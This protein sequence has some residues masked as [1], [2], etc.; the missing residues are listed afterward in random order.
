M[1]TGKK[2]LSIVLLVGIMILTLFGFA[3][4]EV[5]V[6]PA[7][8]IT[9]SATQ[10]GTVTAN[11]ERAAEGNEVTL[12]VTPNAKYVLSQLKANETELTLDEDGAARFTMPATEV[13]ITAEF[14]RE[15]FAVNLPTEVV[16]G[17][18][19][20]DAEK[21]IE[22]AT[23]TLTATPSFGYETKAVTV[24]GEAITAQDG[25]YS[26]VMPGK[27]VDV[28]V[29]YVI[30]KNA[31]TETAPEGVKLTAEAVAGKTATGIFT[32]EYAEEGVSMAAYVEDAMITQ[33]DCVSFYLGANAYANGGL[34]DS[35][36]SIIATVEGVKLYTVADGKYVESADA[37]N[38]QV[39]PWVVNGEVKGYAVKALA[40][41]EML[42]VEK[43]AAKGNVTVLFSL[44]NCDK[45]TLTKIVVYG[46]G[47]ADNADTFALLNEDGTLSE[48]YYKYGAGQLGQGDTAIKTGVH[49]NLSKDYGVNSENYADRKAVLSGHDGSDNNL[50]MFRATGQNLYA[51]AT[52]KLTGIANSSERYGKF[53]IMLF[54]ESAGS[55]FFFYVDA[56][57]G[58]D[59]EVKLDNVKGTE[60]GY[61]SAP[62]GW[63][64]WN[65]ISGTSGSFDLTTKTI[66]LGLTA[67]DG[68]IYMY[69]GDKL[70][71]ETTFDLGDGAVMGFKSFAFNMEVTDYYSTSDLDDPAFK[72]HRVEKTPVALEA[73]FLGDS[74]MDFWTWS[75]FS[76]HTAA[77]EGAKQDIG[78]GGTKISYWTNKIGYVKKMYSSVDKFIFHIGVNDIDDGNTTPEATFELLKEMIAVYQNAFPDAEIYWVS[79]VHN[80]MFANKCANYDKMNQYVYDYAKTIEKLHYIDV[81]SV[82]VD[83][84]GNTRTNMFY[85]GLHFN[86]EYG[87]PLWGK[88]IMEAIGYGDARAEGETLGDIE[89]KYAYNVW[90]F[91]EDGKV[92]KTTASGEQAIYFKDM[93]YATDFVASVDVYS[94]GLSGSDDW[95]KV[96]VILRNDNYSIFGYADTNIYGD[97]KDC[98]IVYRANANNDASV[99]TTANWGWG[100]QGSGGRANES[101]T[102]KY[103][104]ISVAKLGGTIYMLVNGNIVASHT[105]ISGI[106][107]QAFVAGVMGFNRIIEAKNA[108]VVTDKDAVMIALGLKAADAEL[109]GVADDDVWTDEVLS[110]TLTLGKRAEGSYFDV[111]AVKG[112]DGVYF[113]ATIYHKQALT[114]LAQGTDGNWWEWLNLEMRFGTDEGTQRVVYF[115]NGKVNSFGGVVVGDYVTEKSGD[116]NK[117]TVEFFANYM[118]F[119]GYTAENDEIA[120]KF[121]GWVAETGWLAIEATPTVS[122]H[123]LRYKHTATLTGADIEVP[124]V[125][126]KGDVITFKVPLEEGDIVGYV[127]VNGTEIQAKEDVYTIV[128]GDEDVK[129]EIS[130]LGRH[131]VT[132]DN[133][134]GKVAVS[135][136]RPHESDVIEFTQVAPY[137]IQ[138][139]YVNGTE[140]QAQEGKYLYT[141]GQ[142]DLT[143]TATYIVVAGGITIDGKLDA[144]YGQSF[145]F[146]VEGNRDV[147]IYGKNTDYGVVLYLIAHTDNNVDTNETEWHK[148]HNLEFLLNNGDQRYVN[149]R[150]ESQGV[151]EFVRTTEKLSN[152]KYEHRYEVFVAGNFGE[153]VRINYAFKAPT[154][155]ARYEGLSNNSW[156]RSDWWNPV[157]GGIDTNK[158]TLYGYGTARPNNLFASKEGLY[159]TQPTAKNAKIDADFSEYEGLESATRGNENA[160]FT[161]T[162]YTAADGYYLAITILQKNRAAATND[163]WL[164]DNLEM[165]L[166]GRGYGTKIGFSIYDDFLCTFGSITQYAMKRTELTEG[167]YKYKTDVE[168]FIYDKDAADVAY[169]L[170]GCNGNGF[171]SWQSLAWDLADR[172]KLSKDGAVFE[173]NEGYD[174]HALNVDGVKLDG[175][176]DDSFWNGVTE[177][178]NKTSPCYKN[179]GVYAIVQ[180][181]KGNAGVYLAVTM[182]HHKAYNAVVKDSGS[183]WWHYLNIEYR[184]IVGNWDASVQRVACPWNNGALN[185]V[186]G[187]TSVENKDDGLGSYEYKTVFEIFTP[188]EMM[189]ANNPKDDLQLQISFVGENDWNWLLNIWEDSTLPNTVTNEGFVRK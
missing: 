179:Q 137:V 8:E 165:S 18:I 135:N 55:G 118:Y 88:L 31:I 153:N 141:V 171:V 6:V 86:Y 184:F 164:N 170:A 100:A 36:R 94:E 3:A 167:D 176:L 39:A 103:V 67:Y 21:A 66:T 27:N 178:T 71:A 81:T 59:G 84:N 121:L 102:K 115:P 83:E 128:V 56:Y 183:D 29:E 174:L 22:D 189:D 13:V 185:C 147:T 131:N 150:D 127:K 48:N 25:V 80:T 180:A 157:I 4:C 152:G 23:V 63:G 72:A 79:L 175:K 69:L 61:N 107:N 51:T 28:N 163:W 159:T 98:N 136:A 43:E 116:F 20:A 126:R 114:S 34:L 60:L 146:K 12:T 19:A 7:Y 158:L 154:E 155:E 181:K 132:L 119:P 182:Y 40:T 16:G 124:S 47:S 82:G 166:L 140:I 17:T 169:I 187:W 73:L 53:G 138:K 68:W 46:G 108:K 65:T 26:F 161:F 151:T 30:A 148:N 38:A 10:N 143:V 97:S 112:S 62:N 139:L 134:S 32:V 188:Y 92:A 99:Y 144:T 1:K 125:V 5:S 44:G 177:W 77:I 172:I 95:S 78:V 105:G 85:D 11:V 45:S 75:G 186:F 42:G 76:Q 9:V 87:Y 50:A 74:Y 37:V 49:W 91:S 64:N 70:V 33:N 123:G 101:I 54:N 168:L 89:D 93:Q 106:E 113:L 117:T 35:N 111:A 120:V 14:C 110:N 162:G 24:D 90:T 15:T 41:Y 122:T 130:I 96:G 173:N 160:K 129:I 52:F 133:L 145:G 109:D 57:I 58:N 156:D 2:R 149:S 142:E 104:T